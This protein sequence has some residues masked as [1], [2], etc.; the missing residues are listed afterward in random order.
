M[1]E[2]TL[3]TPAR[4]AA[5]F[6]SF[7]PEDSAQIMRTCRKLGITFGNAFPVLSQV[8]LTRVLCRR[9]ISGHIT[10]EEWEYRKK[11]PMTTGGPLN[12]RSFLNREWFER[13]GSEN[14]SL[15]ISFFF[16]TLPFMPLGLASS[17]KPGDPLPTFQSLLTP[18]RFLLRCNITKQQARRLIQHPRFLDIAGARARPRVDRLKAIAVQW[19][20]WYNNAASDQ[21]AISVKEQGVVYGPVLSHGGSSLGNVSSV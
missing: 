10:N 12:L 11:E 6:T 1:T 8:A 14:I 21:P 3:Y 4:S 17:I 5:V 15:S 19:K 18:A 13:G 2:R 16:N 9:Y 20:A 7:S